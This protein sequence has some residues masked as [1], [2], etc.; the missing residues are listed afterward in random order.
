MDKQIKKVRY[1]VIGL[2]HIAQSAVLPGFKNAKNSE[3]KALISGDPVKLKTL[4]KKY[5]VKLTFER[6]N[7]VDCL[8]SGE[9]DAL[10]ISTPNTDHQF[11][12]EEAALRGIHV[13]CEKP[14]ASTSDAC[15]S[16][17]ETAEKTNVK[18]MVGYR[19]HLDPANL[20]AVEIARSGKLGD[21]KIFNSV[22]SFQVK[23]LNNIRLKRAKGGGPL[24]DIGIYCINAARYLF[25]DEPLEVFAQASQS[26]DPR[27]R[28]VPE[29]ISVMMKFP[30]NRVANCVCSFGAADSSRYDLIGTRGSL[31]LNS[32]YDYAN[33][34]ELTVQ[35]GEKKKSIQFAKHDQFGAE[36]VYFSNC[37]L[38]N[39][40]PEPSVIEGLADLMTIQ[41]IEAST[42]SGR[43]EKVDSLTQFKINRPY[44]RQKIQR[45][46]ISEPKSVRAQS[47]SEKHG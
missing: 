45:P 44:P 40:N 24:H 15:W 28:E 30:Q 43:P 39:R 23:D 4:S 35:I 38:K 19:L 34:M 3:L 8:E 36:L 7:F 27:F 41:A 25:A 20:K 5:K 13:L 10:Y 9:I 33:K 46:G 22:F 17:L 2:G 47:P 12:A 14:L 26:E 11:Y 42:K 21:L 16:I 37:I 6:N 32:A 29:M 31:S 18:F 1:A